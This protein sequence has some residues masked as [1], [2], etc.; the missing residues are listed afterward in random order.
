M[1]KSYLYSFGAFAVLTSLPAIF[2]FIV[3]IITFSITHLVFWGCV[4][5]FIWLSFWAIKNNKPKSFFVTFSIVSAIWLLLLLRTIQRIQFVLV[6][7]G[8]ERADGAGSPLAFLIGVVYE[9]FFFIPACFVVF[10]GSWH[11]LNTMRGINNA[12]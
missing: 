12:S 8:M 7:G 3:G 10:F 11:L 2:L 9:Q 5:A 1:P 6:N 4:L